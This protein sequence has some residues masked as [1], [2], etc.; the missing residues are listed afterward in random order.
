[1]VS[2][3]AWVNM[4]Y[5]LFDT[6]AA[7]GQVQLKFVASDEGLGS[8]VEAG[9]DDFLIAGIFGLS[10]AGDAPLAMRVKLE[11]NFP[12][13]F[14]PKTTIRFQLPSADHVLLGIYDARG[15]LLRHLLG[16][17]MPAG[18]H[19][20]T[21]NGQ[22]ALGRQVASG[23]YYCKLSTGSGENLSCRMIMLK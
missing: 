18:D 5:N 1:M 13:P 9:V 16:G 22:D 8:V 20:I 2:T 11:Q 19:A 4:T 21:W 10:G 6:F 23:V 17:Q 15:R 14:N 7:A 3:N 12:N